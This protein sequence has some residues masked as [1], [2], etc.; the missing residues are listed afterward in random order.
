MTPGK[1]L[2]TSWIGHQNKIDAEQFLKERMDSEAYNRGIIKGHKNYLSFLNE[3]GLAPDANNE[4]AD[5]YNAKRM[6]I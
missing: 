5:F 2:N 1:S 6:A 4:A 3:I